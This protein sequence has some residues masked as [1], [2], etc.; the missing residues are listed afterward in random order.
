MVRLSECM[1]YRD[2]R[3]GEVLYEMAGLL[4]AGKSRADGDAKGSNSECEKLRET[5]FSCV[6]KLLEMAGLYGFEGNLWHCYLTFL[7]VNHENTFSTACEIR[8]EVSGSVNDIALHDFG[9]FRELFSYD[10][11]DF[12]WLGD[13]PCLEKLL[14]YEN[15]GTESKIYNSRIRDRICSL[16][17]KLAGDETAQEFM[18]DMV[19]FYKDFGVGKFGLHKAFRIDHDSDGNVQ[20]VPITKIAHVQ[21]ED[22]VGYEIPKQKLVENTACFVRGKKAHTCL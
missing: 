19:Q 17:K 8:G 13:H 2:F 14:H 11:T 9:V 4:A 12:D 1:L 16:S 5:Y 18:S 3:Y 10:I 6:N 22:L 21:L 15:V 7:L 20:I